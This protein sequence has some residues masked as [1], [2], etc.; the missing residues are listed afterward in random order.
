MRNLIQFFIRQSALFVF[1]FYGI[2]SIVLLVRFNSY[3]QSVF[4]SSANEVVGDVYSLAG[5]VTS[6]FGLRDINQDL[7]ER[8]GH[9]EKEIQILK[10]KLLDDKN[11]LSSRDT[12]TKY[13]FIMAQVINNSVTQVENYITLNKGRRDGIAPQM[14][15]VDQNGIIGIVSL[16]SDNYSVVIS[17]LN[18]KLRLS[19]KVKGS[20]YFGSLVW[21]TES[22]EY[23]LLE[24]LPRHVE[25]K[26][27]D[28]I[29]TS[30]YSAAFPEGLPVGVIAGYSRQR[31]DNFYALKIRLSADFHR[32]NDVRVI[33]NNEQQEQLGLEERARK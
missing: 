12:T 3:H 22:A 6:Y 16:V 25:F 1:L 23:A 11:L 30:G 14:G 32:L 5:N 27:G 13:D 2:I 10:E 7:L 9:L 26:E 15:V 21:N 4:F 20:D 29:V 17:L 28:T 24:E 19:A 31:N 8:N 18:T 33:I